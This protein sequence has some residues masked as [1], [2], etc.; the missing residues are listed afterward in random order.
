MSPL[1]DYDHSAVRDPLPPKETA[2][3]PRVPPESLSWCISADALRLFNKAGV[4]LQK[5]HIVEARGDQWGR[6]Y[7]RPVCGAFV[8]HLVAQC[9]P[10]PE[11]WPACRHCSKRRRN[12]GVPLVFY[13]LPPAASR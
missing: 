6:P 3:Q 2:D 8:E 13:D 12:L 9:E 11:G 10:A 1:Y 4:I 7:H 5:A